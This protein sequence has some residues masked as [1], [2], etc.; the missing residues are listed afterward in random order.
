MCGLEPLLREAGSVHERVEFR[1]LHRRMDPPDQWALR[2]AAVTAGRDSLGTDQPCQA[3]DPIA[4]ELRV[5]DDVRRVAH[6][7]G[8]EHLARWQLDVPTDPPLVFMAGVG[9]LEGVRSDRNLQDEIDNVAQRHVADVRCVPAAPAHVVPGPLGGLYDRTD[10]CRP[11]PAARV[12]RLPSAARRVVT[13]TV[14]SSFL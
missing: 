13:P 12:L 9:L 5:L 11:V 14:C 8:H 2:E 3:H 7:T 4:H 1:P 10:N 6:Q